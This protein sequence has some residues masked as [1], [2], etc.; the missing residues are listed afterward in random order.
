[1]SLTYYKFEYL[2]K[3]KLGLG[4]HSRTLLNNM[5]IK[6]HTIYNTIKPTD[7]IYIVE[8]LVSIN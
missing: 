5:A 1:M 6:G 7:L 8:T 4:F 2:N 3:C